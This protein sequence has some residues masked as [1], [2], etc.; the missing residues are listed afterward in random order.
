MFN[1]SPRTKKKEK[2]GD[3]VTSILTRIRLYSHML[4]FVKEKLWIP[5]QHITRNDT[6]P[7]SSSLSLAIANRATI[8]IRINIRKI[9]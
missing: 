1:F 4:F 8:N 7:S 9:G 5:I 6:E 2:D 3:H